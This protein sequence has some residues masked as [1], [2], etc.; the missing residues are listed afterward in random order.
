[1]F[2]TNPIPEQFTEWN[3][4]FN[5]PF[6]R[7]PRITRRFLPQSLRAKWSGPFSI[8][9]NSKTRIFE[10]PWAFFATPIHEGQRILEIG[11]GLSGF[12]FVLARHGCHVVNVDPGMEAK[13]RGWPCNDESIARLN[14]EFG[15][16][17]ELRNTVV[18]NANL[19]SNSFDRAF[20]ISVIE[21]L[22]DD[23]IK[24]AMNI[25]YESLKPGGYFIL[26]IDFF[27]DLAPVT[28][29]SS[30]KFGTNVKVKDIV[31]IAPFDLVKGNPSELYGFQEFSAQ[32]ANSNRSS[33]IFG[34]YPV[35]AQCLVLQ[36]KE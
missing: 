4:Q 27:L 23:D 22:P 7:L 5:A 29:K 34:N 36:K 11:G 28:T 10:Y 1:M 35:V 2:A 16:S 12:Q 26:T 19:E 32:S 8:Q 3:N 13:G 14:R 9:P 17:V 25:V 6:G 31:D 30:N 24:D 18:T 15:T 21:H 20:C 33:Y